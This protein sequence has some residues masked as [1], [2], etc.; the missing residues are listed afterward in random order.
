[1]DTL[2]FE[3]LLLKTTFCCMASDGVLEQSEINLIKKMCDA[4][5][6]FNDIDLA[7]E[8]NRYIEGLNEHGVAFVRGYL[9]ELDSSELTK[10][11]ELQIVDFSIKTILAD[12]EIDYAEVKFFK[13]IRHRLNLTDD[14]ILNQYEDIDI[15]LEEDVHTG[16]L[17]EHL[18]NQYF[19]TVS[20]PK[21][22]RVDFPDLNS[23]A[24]SK[25]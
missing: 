5:D 8:V 6:Y 17:L 13:I 10:E 21:F 22:E 15:F 25:P 11:Q 24:E 14:D 7:K 16:S 23:E 9:D 19:S 1:M 18:S 4:S 3:Q 12:D 20:L 2:P